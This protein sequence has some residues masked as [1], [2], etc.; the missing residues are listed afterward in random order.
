MR[1]A[2]GP[3]VAIVGLILVFVGVALGANS[4]HQMCLAAYEVK[5]AKHELC[6][7]RVKAGGPVFEENIGKM[8]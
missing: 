5:T 8:P 4:P 1:Y 7:A 6:V 3:I 2:I